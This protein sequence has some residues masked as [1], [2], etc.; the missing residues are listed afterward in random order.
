GR[1]PRVDANSHETVILGGC[2]VDPPI[3]YESRDQFRVELAPKAGARVSL[4]IR[5]GE[6]PPD[7]RYGQLVEF[8]ARIRPVRNFHNPGS[9]DYAG[10][11]ARRQIFWTASV[12]AGAPIQV[13]P[14]RCGSR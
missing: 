5:D 7:L 9:F 10:Y 12:R 13:L 11:S 6:T 4:T 3:F 8:E 14:G 1:A 2:V